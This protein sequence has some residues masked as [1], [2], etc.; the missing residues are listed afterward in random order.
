MH[1]FPLPRFLSLRVMATKQSSSS[2]TCSTT[3]V[4]ADPSTF[5]ALVQKLTGP[6]EDSSGKLLP[7]TVPARLVGKSVSADMGPRRSTFKLQERRQTMK[8][9]GLKLGSIQQRNIKGEALL[10]SPISPLDFFSFS[11][12]TPISP[13]SSSS[14]CSSWDV[15]KEEKAISEKGF[16]LHPSTPRSSKPELLPLFPLHSPGESSS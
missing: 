15:L 14:S 5:R 8:M 11:P 12:K 6:N 9:L 13:P 2:D 7:V 3:F 4:Q 10:V 16:Y 1:F